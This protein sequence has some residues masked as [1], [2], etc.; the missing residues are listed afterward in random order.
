MEKDETDDMRFIEKLMIRRGTGGL[1]QSSSD[2]RNSIS[3]RKTLQRER[4]FSKYLE[5]SEIDQKI[6]DLSANTEI[7]L[8]EVE[9][10]WISMKPVSMDEIIENKEKFN[11]FYKKIV[12]GNE[13]WIKHK[14]EENPLYFENLAKPQSPKYLV[15]AC[16]DS[17]VVINEFTRT[18]PGDVF[19]HRNIGNIIVSTDFNCQ[20]V[21]HYAVEYF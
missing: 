9:S 21:I 3:G 7:D 20:S 1:R 5:E 6:E 17:R 14:K 16:S 18:E 11:D 12:V 2:V 15:I 10:K 8:E 13:E 4:E 19:T